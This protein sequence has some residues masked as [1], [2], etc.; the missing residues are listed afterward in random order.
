MS[1]SNKNKKSLFT[2]LEEVYKRS[3]RN[4]EQEHNFLRFGKVLMHTDLLVLWIC[5]FYSGMSYIF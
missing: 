3:Q 5:Q 4:S 1:L 2:N